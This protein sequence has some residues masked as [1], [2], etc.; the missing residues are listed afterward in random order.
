VQD[1]IETLMAEHRVIE[2]V[3]SA[4]EA[5]ANRMAP[6]PFFEEVVDF[7]ASYADGSHH[8]KE[9]GGLFPALIARGMSREAGPVAVML[10]E[11]EL[12]R[13]CVAR[14]RE[15]IAAGDASAAG[16]AAADYAALLRQH[17]AKEDGVLYP[18]ARDL[19]A[20]EQLAALA[21]GFEEDE[22]ARSRSKRYQDLAARLVAEAHAG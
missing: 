20:A 21:A 18:M 6:L 1:P 11:H 16:A 3:L 19:L 14:M 15:A 17:I 2:Q 9:E 12:G 8:D 13:T 4:I 22:A 7:I 10:H 5:N